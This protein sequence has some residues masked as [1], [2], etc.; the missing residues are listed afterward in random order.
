MEFYLFFNCFILVLIG[1]FVVFNIKTYTE[2]RR[3]NIIA[4]QKCSRLESDFAYEEKKHEINSRNLIL[5]DE[6][7][8]DLFEKLFKITRDILLVQKIILNNHFQ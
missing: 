4:K 5:L 1:V 3:I 8:K 7:H 6:L 2:T